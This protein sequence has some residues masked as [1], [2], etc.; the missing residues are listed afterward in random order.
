MIEV[1]IIV[2]VYKVEQ[3]IHVCVDSIL[4]QTFSNFELI[5]VDDGSPDN[6]PAICDEYAKNDSRIRVIHK[7]NGGIS[8]ARN[9]GLSAATGKYIMFCD[10]DDYVSPIW[11]ESL[12]EQICKSPDA[13]IYS[14]II[15]VNDACK[16]SPF[17]AA[18][19][20]QVLQTDYYH[21]FTS[22]LS[23][24]VWNKIYSAEV[25]RSNA[26]SFDETKRLAEDVDFNLKYLQ[27]CDGYIYIPKQTYAYVQHDGSV[28]HKYN[29][30]WFRMHLAP[31]YDRVPFIG[32]AHLSDYCDAWLY[33]FLTF[34]TIVFDKRNHWSLFKK[35]AY[36]QKMI[37][38]KEFQ[39]CL[40]NAS[41]KSE[42][43]LVLKIL[44]LKNYP[45]FWLFD[46]TV[47]FVHRIK[48]FGK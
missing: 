32:E 5:L 12:Y 18:C 33:M 8:S 46:K 29:P 48:S 37:Q 15:R 39:F 14:N 36:N 22:G 41:G 30:D 31:F 20:E 27:Y 9:A 25:I 3:Y 19:E 10:S 21:A 6:C 40:K 43:P 42:N 2:P 4:N 1:S 13:C 7:D 38:S 16:Q 26:L 24:Y 34:F 45:L 44:K 28:M 35:F 17:N 11:C 23:A 47:S